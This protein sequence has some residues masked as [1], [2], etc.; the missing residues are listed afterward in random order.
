MVAHIVFKRIRFPFFIVQAR[1]PPQRIVAE[2]QRIPRRIGAQRDLASGVAGKERDLSAKTL[3]AEQLACRVIRKLHGAAIRAG[4][5]VQPVC[6]G[7]AVA[8]DIACGVDLMRQPAPF[9]VTPARQ[10]VRAVPVLRYLAA[11]VITPVQGVTCRIMDNGVITVSI[12]L[13]PGDVVQGIGDAEYIPCIV[14]VICP[15]SLTGLYPFHGE[16]K[17][18]QPGDGGFLPQCIREHGHI[19]IVIIRIRFGIPQRIGVAE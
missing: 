3:L 9:V 15:Y 11:P 16:R 10:T 4:E 17:T 13:Q 7:I 6:C 2:P 18:G 19:A 14:I 12:P 1:Q 8:A 5:G